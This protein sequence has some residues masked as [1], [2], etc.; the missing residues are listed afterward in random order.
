[1]LDLKYTEHVKLNRVID[2][3]GFRVLKEMEN[4][5]LQGITTQTER[6]RYFTLLTW[7]YDL[8]LIHI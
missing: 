8:S 3:L 5:F 1:M 7:V 2:P 4:R 6:L